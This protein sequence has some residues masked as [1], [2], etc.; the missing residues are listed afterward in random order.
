MPALVTTAGADPRQNIK[1]SAFGSISGAGPGR[2]VQLA[3]KFT[4]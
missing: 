3:M 4:F 2:N 1:T